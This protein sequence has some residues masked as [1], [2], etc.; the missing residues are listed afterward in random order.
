MNHRHHNYN[1]NDSIPI[2]RSD[3]YMSPQ[4][5][6]TNCISTKNV[7][8]LIFCVGVICLFGKL[9]GANATTPSNVINV[10]N[11]NENIQH[12]LIRPIEYS[13]TFTQHDDIEI[14]KSTEELE[15]QYLEIELELAK[16]KSNNVEKLNDIHAE[17]LTLEEEYY[18]NLQKQIEQHYELLKDKYVLAVEKKALEEKLRTVNENL[19]VKNSKLKESENKQ[20]NIVNNK[21]TTSA[22]TIAEEKRTIDEQRVKSRQLI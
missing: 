22:N 4:R 17:K 6:Q 20:H 10:L 1:Y 7:L 19:S 14:L 11:D 2:E 18:A 13:T 16:Q 5:K 3:I 8:V 9:N 21:A 12:K 15:I